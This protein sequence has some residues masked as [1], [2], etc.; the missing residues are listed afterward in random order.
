[1][2]QL[3]YFLNSLLFPVTYVLNGIGGAIF[4]LNQFRFYSNGVVQ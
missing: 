3:G 1:M 2:A 4:A